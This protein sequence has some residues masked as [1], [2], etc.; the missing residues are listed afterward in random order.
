MVLSLH[1]RCS[2]KANTTQLAMMVSSTAY[3]NG[4][5]QVKEKVYE[6]INIIRE[7]FYP[8]PRIEFWI[9]CI[10]QKCADHYHNSDTITKT[11]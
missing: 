6:M 9:F 11:G 4:V 7:T 2:S 5:K 3:S 10:F 1:G 8:E